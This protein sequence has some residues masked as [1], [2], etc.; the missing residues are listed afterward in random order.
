MKKKDNFTI[1][2]QGTTSCEH[3]LI[4]ERRMRRANKILEQQRQLQY[5]TKNDDNTH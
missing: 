2:I 1:R 3:P 4:M 5:K